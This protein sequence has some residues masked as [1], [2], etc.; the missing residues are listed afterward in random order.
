MTN[1]KFFRRPAQRHIEPVPGEQR[2]QRGPV[3]DAE[4]AGRRG[5][6]CVCRVALLTPSPAR[7]GVE[8]T[9]LRA[10]RPSCR[11]LSKAEW[12]LTFRSRPV[13]SD[14]LSSAIADEAKPAETHEHQRPGRGLGNS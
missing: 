12:R 8:R 11:G 1:F 6:R 9:G 10:E 13:L 4:M 7:S 14:P 3:V 5:S 2:D